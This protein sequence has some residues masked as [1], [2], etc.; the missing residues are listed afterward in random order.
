MDIL[1]WIII[2]AAASA[3][4]AQLLG[5]ILSFFMDQTLLVGVITAPIAGVFLW[6]VGITDWTLVIGALA[7]G[8]FA[9][10]SIKLLNR[11]VPVQ[12]I[13]RGR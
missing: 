9:T 7:G 2:A 3:F 12:T 13:P 10:A 5:V 6:L 8:F 1:I 11:P 4:T